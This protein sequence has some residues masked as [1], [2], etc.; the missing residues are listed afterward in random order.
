MFVGC[1]C[2]CNPPESL[3]SNILS[4][5][6]VSSLSGSIRSFGSSF[7]DPGGTYPT[8]G[9]VPCR[10]S[11]AALAYEFDWDYN[12]EL[13][14]A[15]DVRPC[16]SA[17]RSVKKIIVRRY[18]VKDV[19]GRE[20]PNYCWYRSSERAYLASVDGRLNPFNP[21]YECLSYSAANNAII[22]PPGAGYWPHFA[23]FQMYPQPPDRPIAWI[24]FVTRYYTL[25]ERARILTIT[26]EASYVLNIPAGADWIAFNDQG[27][28]FWNIPCLTPLTYDLQF[29]Q[30]PTVIDEDLG[31]G[32]AGS[33]FNP[34]NRGVWG[35]APCKQVRFSGFDMNLPRQITLRP[36]PA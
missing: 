30:N 5:A 10:D 23:N 34:Y 8:A 3:G 6:S 4:G 13:G 9:C 35:G 29:I 2:H 16:C 22:F 15:N 28:G 12:G 7:A 14:D 25:N 24:S 31:P 11:V 19:F 36:V 17:Y 32:W 1:G 27:Q 21:T 18:S 33:H 20:D 26:S